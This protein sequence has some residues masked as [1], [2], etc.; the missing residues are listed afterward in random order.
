MQSAGHV[1]KIVVRAPRLDGVPSLNAPGFTPARGVHLVVG[2][3][4]GFGLATARWLVDKGVDR[5]VVASRAGVIDPAFLPA[6]RPCAPGAC[7]LRPAR[8][9]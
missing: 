2:G 1:G 8:W 6:V 9:T 7:C 3:T 5:I 4:R